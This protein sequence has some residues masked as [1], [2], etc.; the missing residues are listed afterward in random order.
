[1]SATDAACS[2][3][4]VLFAAAAIYELRHRVLPRISGW[5]VRIDGLLH[6]VMAV[7]MS[8]TPWNWGAQVPA[9][10][11]ASSSRPQHCGS[12]GSGHQTP[13]VHAGHSL[14][15]PIAHEAGTGIR[16]S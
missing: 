8:A 10:A 1:M 5:S 6:T 11:Q 16:R 2:M 15:D 13:A 7:A 14:G 4:T 12:P 3:L 9:R